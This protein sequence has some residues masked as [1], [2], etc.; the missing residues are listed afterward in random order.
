MIRWSLIGAA[1]VVVLGLG[2]QR[3]VHP[4]VGTGMPPPSW[5]EVE[6]QPAF[7][8]E[9]E[10]APEVVQ[11]GPKEVA[12]RH[13]LVMYRGAARVPVAVVRTR[14]EARVR[15][16]EALQRARNGEDFAVLVAEYSDEPGAAERGG[17]LGTFTRDQMVK[18]FSDAAFALQPGEISD[19][20]ETQFG[21]HVIQR[22]E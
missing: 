6:Q 10:A 9:S 17:S 5:V 1:A 15:A 18:P 3:S 2:C 21:F 7:A 14:D 22:T 8:E 20:V 16:Q 12:A 13:I 19:L 11:P 4:R